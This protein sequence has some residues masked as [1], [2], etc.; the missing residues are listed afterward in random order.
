MI[1][2][3]NYPYSQGNRLDDRNTYFYV[4]FQGIA[5]IS[6]W[7]ESRTSTLKKLGMAEPFLI[8]KPEVNINLNETVVTEVLLKRIY[9]GLSIEATN[10][11]NNDIL[12][13]LL[14]RFEVTK[15]IHVSY[16]ENFRPGAD[17]PF[18]NLYLYLIFGQVLD[19]AYEKCGKLF[20]LNGMIKIIDT[21][22]SL[23]ASLVNEEKQAL[24]WLI[25]REYKY[26][27]HIAKTQKTII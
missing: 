23:M 14:Q 26:I 24:A 9:S 1:R 13:K 21:L 27:E 7:K 17:I 3:A 10:V 5:F 11:D 16:P 22:C 2:S 6:A 18:N 12:N 8:K 4:P 15:R 20:Y 25:N 19:K